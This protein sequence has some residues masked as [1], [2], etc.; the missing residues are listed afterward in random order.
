MSAI[1]GILKRKGGI[2]DRSV[3]ASMALSMVHRG[4]DGCSA[5]HRDSIGFFHCMLY[6]TPESLFEILPGVDASN[7]LYITVDARLDNREELAAA[8]HVDSQ[9]LALIPDSK[10]IILAYRQWGEQCPGHLLGDFSFALWDR[11]LRQLLCV[12]DHMGV[13]PLCYYVSETMVVFASETRALLHVPEIPK[14]INE[15]RIGDFLGYQIEGIDK[16]STFYRNIFRLPP[17]HYL[18]VSSTGVS[19]HRYWQLEEGHG[20]SSAKSDNEQLEEFDEI[21]TRAV[22]V[23]LRSNSPVS[24]MLS[25]GMDSSAIVGVARSLKGHDHSIPFRVYSASS[26]NTDTCRENYFTKLIVDQGGLSCISIKPV[27]IAKHQNEL[28]RLL[29]LLENPFDAHMVLPMLIY[30]AARENNS[31]VVL[32]GVD[33]DMVHSLPASYPS[34]LL[35]QGHIRLALSELR[36]LK[37]KYYSASQS[38]PRLF[39]RTIKQAFAPHWLSLLKEKIPFGCS[40][41]NEENKT[42]LKNDVYQRLEVSK[43]LKQ[44][45]QYG[46]LNGNQSYQRQH[47]QTILHPDLTVAIERYDR[48][49]ALCSIEPRHPMLD[50][51]LIEYS[52]NSSWNVLVRNGWSK[53]HLRCCA[54]KYLPA[55]VC[56]RR[57]REHVGYEFIVGIMQNP[58]LVT[59]MA[60]RI[61]QESKLL[62]QYIGQ[63]DLINLTNVN[64]FSIM[65]RDAINMVNIYC[66]VLWLKAQQ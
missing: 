38:Y 22:K 26:N 56:W 17:A 27:Y 46:L 8:L 29:G 28:N 35:R 41:T 21:F 13:K 30:L 45:R 19:I 6:S 66:F 53:Y 10:L 34:L 58:Q 49:A 12:R 50:K 5:L 63:K 24:S 3:L 4:P 55:E 25:G 48:V 20:D 23:R 14:D 65:N 9:Q 44:Y 11:K 54:E 42:I 64:N 36:H 60:G 2:P 1:G 31:R 32:D 43:R 51:R 7:D 33:G 37:E 18:K 61:C 39:Y 52:V 59:K 16:T 57:G 40:F 15:E 47:I 62:L